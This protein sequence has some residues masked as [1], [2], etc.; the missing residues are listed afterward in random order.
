MR[1]IRPE[2]EPL[3][4]DF[5]KT[6]SQES[7]YL[8]YF[9]NLKLGQRISHERL[10]RICFIDYD[11]ETAL[12]AERVDGAT[13]R[14]DIVGVGRLSRLHGTDD[15]EY[16]IIVSDAFQGKGLGTELLKRLVQ[17]GRREG[18]KRIVASILPENTGMLKVSER[19]GFALLP[20][21]RQTVFVVLDL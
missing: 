6:L 15:G 20:K 2:D 11:R 14:A 1:P 5:H 19:L 10:R 16:A 18:M 17:I 9:Q 7:V 21:D 13:G 8:R 3:I 4:V 12:V